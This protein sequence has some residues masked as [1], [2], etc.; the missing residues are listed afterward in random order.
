M[1]PQIKTQARMDGFGAFMMCLVAAYL[2]AEFFRAG[3][4]TGAT[5]LFLV[6]LMFGWLVC[7]WGYLLY[8][9]MAAT[10]AGRFIAGALIGAGIGWG[11]GKVLGCGGG[12][13]TG[14]PHTP[15][16]EAYWINYCVAVFG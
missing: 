5:R 8:P 11:V 15:K 13:P 14:I 10:G 2:N 7:Q 1:S 12:P 3:G 4:A 6:A 9:R 16:G